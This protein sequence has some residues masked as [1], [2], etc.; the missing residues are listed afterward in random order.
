MMTE[1][2]TP[3]PPGPAADPF[4]TPPP[5]PGWSAV[6]PPAP[7]PTTKFCHACGETIDARAEICPKC[8]VRQPHIAGMPGGGIQVNANA[9]TRTG[10]TKLVAAL[11]AIFLGGLGVHKF[12]LGQMGM[13]LLYLVFCWTFIPAIVGFIEGIL[14]LVQSDE[15]WLAKYGDV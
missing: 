13:G 15:Q 7:A 10:K 1:G 14:W 8:G 6:P 9:V 2:T 11:L 5:Q 12:Y 4:G 3:P